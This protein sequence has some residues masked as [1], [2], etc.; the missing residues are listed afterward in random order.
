MKNIA[1]ITGASSGIGRE[2]VLQSPAV[3]PE[4]EEYWLIA[5]R[6]DKLEEYK[7]LLP[8]KEIRVIPMDLCKSESFSELSKLLAEEKPQVSLLVNNA[9]CGFLSNVGEG[10]L[11]QQTR[12][13]ELNV[14]GLTAVTHLVVPYMKAG[15][16]IICLSSIA[17]FCPTSRMTV[18]SSTK[19]YVS[20]FSRGLGDE[21]RPKGVSVTAVCPGPMDTEFIRIGNIKGR[22]KTFDVL[23][24]C[25][26]KK[27]AAGALKAAKR[28]RA[29]YTPRAFYK[30]YRVV[31][32]ITPGAL[33]VK[34]AR[35]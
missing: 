8:E 20:S 1:I 12:M 31:A 30:F 26:P 9:G 28:G 35:T 18:Y 21:L 6:A 32:K 16:R 3:F 14:L 13:V 23:P 4:I 11:S 5:R 2:F 25:D 29:L 27:V 33:M 10:P 24:Y 15:G 7:A 19:A 34:L 22:S 17:S